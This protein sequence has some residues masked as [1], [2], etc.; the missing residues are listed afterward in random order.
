[1]FAF[2]YQTFW[3]KYKFGLYG[4]FGNALDEKGERFFIS[5][6]GNR[7]GAKPP[8]CAAITVLHIPAEERKLD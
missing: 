4:S 8:E 1:V 6:D 2:L 3:D 5:W 7:E